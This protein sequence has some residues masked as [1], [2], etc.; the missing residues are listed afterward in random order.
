MFLEGFV[1]PFFCYQNQMCT[2]GSITS[3][4]KGGGS[5]TLWKNSIKKF[6]FSVW[7][8]LDKTNINATGC[9][10]KKGDLQND[11]RL[12]DLYGI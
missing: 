6:I 3:E 12:L 9:H 10:K 1:F 8:P 7:L 5:D 11:V 2:T 4:N